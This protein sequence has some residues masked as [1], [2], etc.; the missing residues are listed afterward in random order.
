MPSRFFNEKIFTGIIMSGK[1]VSK[2]HYGPPVGSNKALTSINTS[3]SHHDASS[4]LLRPQVPHKHSTIAD[5]VKN[6]NPST[7]T[8]RYTPLQYINIFIGPKDFTTNTSKLA[9]LCNPSTI[10]P[11]TTPATI[12]NYINKPEILPIITLE[13]EWIKETPTK[14]IK[15]IFPPEFHYPP[16]DTT[17]TRTF[18]EFILVDID[19]AE[20]SHTPDFNG[21]IMYSKIKYYRL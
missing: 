1:T 21:H 9:T 5:V 4:L 15:A 20:I 12:E 16:I 7:S 6:P 14:T 19:S 8:N 10:N 18:Y 3:K 11:Q 17:K 2:D 13:K